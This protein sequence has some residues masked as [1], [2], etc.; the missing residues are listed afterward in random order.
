MSCLHFTASS[1][2]TLQ[3]FFVAWIGKVIKPI[4][5]V[6]PRFGE[7]CNLVSGQESF[8][9]KTVPKETCQ[10]LRE[11][12]IYATLQPS[13]P[14]VSFFSKRFGFWLNNHRSYQII[15]SNLQTKN[16]WNLN[17]ITFTFLLII[18]VYFA[19]WKW[20]KQV[21]RTS[22]MQQDTDLYLTLTYK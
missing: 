13:G 1:Q 6:S 16:P 5:G 20:E 2:V 19:L 22:Y 9:D 8:T 3:K 15:F 11:L 18:S 10:G 4:P 17:R 21:D 7:H 12:C 14:S